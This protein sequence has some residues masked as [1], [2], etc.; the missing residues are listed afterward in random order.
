MAQNN[1]QVNITF[2]AF[3]ND[4]NKALTEMNAETRRARQEMQ[5]T[6]EQLKANGTESEK[7]EAKL[8]GLEKQQEIAARKTEL[9]RQ[10]LEQ[11]KLTFG[12]NSVEAGRLADQLLSLQIAEQ[13]LANEV[14]KTEQ[15][16][17]KHSKS[18]RD[19]NN[20]LALVEGSIDDFADVLG[21]DLV[22]ALN[23]GTA[24]SKQIERAI[25]LIGRSALGAQTDL[26]QLRT[27]LNQVDNGANIDAIRVDLQQLGAEAQEAETSIGG[28]KD[29]LAGLAGG[30]VAGVGLAGTIEK[31]LDVSSL[32]TKIAVSFD[33]P[34]ESINVVEQTV[35]KL[36]AYG[37]EGEEALEGIRRQFAL[38]KDASAEANASFV[39]GAGV[40]AKAYAGIDLI[41]LIQETNEFAAALEIS[42]DEAL[43]M[44]NVL[45]KGGF[46][47]EQ[48]DILSEYGLQMKQIGFSSAE[49]QAI[50]EKGVDTKSWNIDNLNDGIKEANIVMKEFGYEV[51]KAVDNLL[52]GTDLSSK[53]LQEWGKAVAGGGKEGAQAMADVSAW[54]RTIEDDA[55]RNELAIAVFGTK[56]EDQGDNLISVFEGIV[57]AQDK[58]V[59]NQN[60][61]QAAIDRT[62]A[63]PLNRIRD[64]INQVME[65]LRPTLTMIAE[66]T[67][68]VANW[69]AQ[70][71]QLSAALIAI[72][73]VIG[74]VTGAFAFLMPA[75]GALVTSWPIL[76]AGISSVLAPIALAVV[77]IGAIGVALVAL[78]QNSETF[79][80]NVLAIFEAVRTTTMEI[81]EAIATFIGEKIAQI[82]AF[83]QE[84][85]PQI[86][87]AVEV[88]FNAIKNVI[89]T[90]MPA[91]QFVIEY[92]W[93]AIKN[94]IDGA[95]NIIMGLVKTFSSMLT[96]D[97]SGMWE[98][99][100]K[101]FSGAIDLVMGLMSLSF[102]G[103][104][105]TLITNLAKTAVNLI[106]NKWT[107]IVNLFKSAT[108]TVGS[109]VKTWVT[110]IINFVKNLSTN[111]KAIIDSLKTQ[112]AKKFSE[113]STAVIDAIKGLP[114]KMLQ[115]GK[116]IVSGLIKGIGGMF[117]DIK[118]KVEEMASKLPEWA[119]KIL[120]IASPSK[121]FEQIGKW[122]GEG[123]A[124]GITKSEGTVEKSLE[125]LGYLMLDVADHY[126]SEQKKVQQQYTKDI[127]KLNKESADKIAKLQDKSE[128][129]ILKIKATANKKKRNLTV[130]E[131][132]AI[133]K[134]EGESAK[135][136]EKLKAQNAEKLLALETKS[137]K[138]KYK[139]SVEA[140]KEYLA[141]VQAFV[142]DRKSLGLMSITEEARIWEESANLFSEGTN[143]R[144][145]AQQ[146]YKKVLETV[147]KE[148]TDVNEKHL[149]EVQRINDDLIKN[150]QALTKVYD[151]ELN[152]RY[153]QIV[154]TYGLFDEVGTE[155]PVSK[156]DIT[157]NLQDQV[158]AV[159]NWTMQIEQLKNRN[160]SA[161][162]LDEL[163][164]MGPKAIEKL[165]A[166]NS[167]TDFE[168]TN[169]ESMYSQKMRDAKE[170]ATKELEPLKADTQKQIEGLRE[171]AN[172]ELD[173][174]NTQ[175]NEAIRGI[176]GD[177]DTELQSL[178]SIGKNAGEG[179]LKGLSSTAPSIQ[180]KAKE[181]ANSVSKTMK[182]ALQIKSPSRVT[183]GFGVNVNEGFVNG[184]DKTKNKVAKV[185]GNI[186]NSVPK[187]LSNIAN[188][189]DLNGQLQLGGASM[190]SIITHNINNKPIINLNIAAAPIYL[191]G[192]QLAEATF[193]T[194]GNL[195]HSNVKMAA[196]MRGV[197]N[198]G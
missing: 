116:D 84:N 23:N 143:E 82:L 94:V 146:N 93:N 81:F 145:K 63:D 151:D 135:E 48:L 133:K 114:A 173:K 142:D 166:L 130:A 170:A 36:E 186:Y 96:G 27:A 104:I 108:T 26:T 6:Q 14:N 188:G 121:V 52:A 47:P 86:L 147:N 68:Q 18:V 159:R 156:I 74:I 87:A 158:M 10:Q 25:S 179:L 7:L 187:Q 20:T 16:V 95:L 177:T 120:G 160:I 57:N 49:I 60:E 106:K 91:I 53:Q 119:R 11:A 176:V 67:A 38:N 171:A 167:M 54:L 194:V 43:A 163:Q 190:D 127:E 19:L 12:E 118:A 56:A 58:T 32:N 148:I 138:D 117:G 29:S 9:A 35:K 191:D 24:D 110:N 80:T 196:T 144:I 182:N 72:A 134:I 137:S 185:M 88:A 181:I 124:I 28:L 51:P 21:N 98:G 65:N 164:E 192:D 169:F 161:G 128:D 150:E 139:L 39:Q 129:K 132:N 34:E 76:A 157:K 198:M 195:Q 197:N 175:W 168:L 111:F 61:W 30:A 165:R 73:T 149:S 180:K 83:W 140:D 55:L 183:Y 193:E 122:T 136:V 40:V 66:F 89:E 101:V 90:V 102:V 78:W 107:S 75:V 37:V 45:M 42:N 85:G 126:V 33:I 59:E 125:D 8:K 13:R 31:A 69:V 189:M 22:Q 174:L 109:T 50:F 97:F 44:T 99:I 41:E 71:A 79:R 155:D 172:I 105:R 141:T 162:L 178:E 70:N 112:V 46:P 64:A 62:N 113:I 100:K 4:Y 77:A 15:A 5:L 103:G 152:R 3:N 1:N 115:I 153:Q 154:N 92:V 131:K 17:N 184:L 2:R 123:L